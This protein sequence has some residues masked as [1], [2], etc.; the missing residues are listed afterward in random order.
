MIRRLATLVAL[1]PAAALAAPDEVPSPSSNLDVRPAALEFNWTPMAMPDGGHTAFASLNYLVAVD[2]DWSI[3]PGVYG[4]AK[5]NYG[6][7]FTVGFTG[8]RRWRLSE[9]TNVVAGLYVGAGGGLSSE[10]MRFGGGLMLRPELSLRTRFGAWYGGVGFSQIRFPSGNV[11]GDAGLAVTV[12]RYLDFAGHAT[13]DAGRRAQSDQRTGLGF[14]EISLTAGSERPS[15][16]SRDRTGKPY[17][18]AVGKAGADL[19]QYGAEGRWWGVEAAGAAQG[20]VDGYMEVLGQVGQD[21]AVPGTP[22]LRVGVQGGV[23]LGGGGNV[24]T[25]NGWLLRAGPTL[26]WITPWGPSVRVDAGVTHAPSGEYT[27]RFVRA[28]L[29]LPLDRVPQPSGADPGGTVR[30]QQLGASVTH[31]PRMRFKDGSEESVS[32]LALVMSRDFSPRVYGV[33]QAGSAAWGRAGAYS[34]GLFGLGVQSDPV[35]SRLRLG[36]EGLLGAAGGGG[37]AVGGGAVAQLEVWAQWAVTDGLRLRAGLGQFRT[38]RSD[39][40]AAALSQVQLSYAFGT[41][42][43]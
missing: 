41:L 19:R 28:A 40:Q 27:A 25:G 36:A 22:R 38:L 13:A 26:R 23:G 43:R 37:V 11:K 5:G 9:E 3:G 24:D 17:T 1:L 21:W 32:H 15:A 14:D 34:F 12:G 2:D 18:G 7:I 6:G 31:V 10:D 29:S 35:W 8:Q 33:A 42:Q 16:S 4:T 20:G 30:V 39:D